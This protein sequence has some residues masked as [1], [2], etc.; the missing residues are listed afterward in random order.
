[1]PY[2]IIKRSGAKPWKIINKDTGKQVGSSTSETKA[3]ASVRARLG[4]S[5]GWKATGRQ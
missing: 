5:H 2:K 1:M 4:A 3:E